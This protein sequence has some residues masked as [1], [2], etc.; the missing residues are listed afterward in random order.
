MKP[1]VKKKHLEI[2]LNFINGSNEDQK[3]FI[4][5]DLIEILDDYRI[6]NLLQKEPLGKKVLEKI[7]QFVIE[8]KDNEAEWNAI[9]SL[10]RFYFGKMEEIPEIIFEATKKSL[11]S[12]NYWT[13]ATTC[14]LVLRLGKREFY[15][16]ATDTID[17]LI[18]EMEKEKI[19]DPLLVEY[20]LTFVDLLDDNRRPNSFLGRL[21]NLKSKK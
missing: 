1:E 7:A 5:R 8:T 16:Q 15:L 3:D 21:A 17:E 10:T 12:P 11:V 20:L 6:I 14:F 9:L 2:F 13:K 19:K 4:K 18:S